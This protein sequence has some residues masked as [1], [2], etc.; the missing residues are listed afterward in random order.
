MKIFTPLS[1]RKSYYLTHP[2][3]LISEIWSD[4]QCA[5]QRATKGYCYRDL[6]SIDYWF[7]DLIPRMLDDFRKQTD[8]YPT[9]LDEKQWDTI[10]KNMIECFKNANDET[11]DFV[12]PY[13][14]E[15]WDKIIS[16]WDLKNGTLHCNIQDQYKILQKNYFDKEKEKD[17]YMDDQLKKGL[18][19]FGKYFWHLWW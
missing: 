9:N 5:W 16:E 3:R 15:Y 8:G 6:W 7:L 2:L 1:Y 12:N 11:T 17:I 19:L 10:L 14:E 18:E 4:I 13:K